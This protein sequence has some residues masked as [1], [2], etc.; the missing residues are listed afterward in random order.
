MSFS[1]NGRTGIGL[2]L[3]TFRKDLFY[4]TTFTLK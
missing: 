3:N 2:R 4:N 1:F